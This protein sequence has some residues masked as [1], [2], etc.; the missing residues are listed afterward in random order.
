MLTPVFLY[1]GE[2]LLATVFA[3][4]NGPGDMFI[5]DGLP[6]VFLLADLGLRMNSSIAFSATSSFY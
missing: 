6:I 3:D 4:P 5:D 2:P 1:D